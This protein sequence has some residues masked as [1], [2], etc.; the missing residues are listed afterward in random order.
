MAKVID[1]RKVKKELVRLLQKNVKLRKT[2]LN[3]LLKEWRNT[4]KKG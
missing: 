3:D 1:F 2:D 4:I